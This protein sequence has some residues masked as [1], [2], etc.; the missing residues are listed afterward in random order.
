[1]RTAAGIGGALLGFALACGPSPFSCDD[2]AQCSRAPDGACEAGGAC[3]YPDTACESG[4]RYSGLGPLRPGECTD[5]ERGTG[6]S[7][8]DGTTGGAS[9]GSSVGDTL[10]L[11]EGSSSDDA[12]GEEST[13]GDD[14][15]VC[16]GI[17]CSGEGTCVVVD[18]E[19]TC[20]CDPG[21]TMVGTECL[22]DPCETTTC[23]FVDD[24]DGDDMAEGSREAPWRTADRVETAIGDAMPG[25]HFLFR[26][27]GTFTGGEIL[28]VSGVDGTAEAPIVIGAYGPV[29]EARPRMIPLSFQ[30][31][32]SSYIVVRD[33]MIEGY[34]DGGPCFNFDRTDHITIH[35]NETTDCAIRAF[36][37]WNQASHTT[38]FRNAFRDG[39]NKTSIFISDTSWS[40]P[41][42][43]VGSHHWIA[44]NV[45]ANNLE[46]GIE[47]VIADDAGG[48][49]KIVGNQ[50]ADVARRGIVLA[51]RYGWVVNNTVVNA[52]T[53]T[54][55]ESSG[56]FAG[57]GDFVVRG[58][59]VAT[60]DAGIEVNGGGEVAANTVLQGAAQR[61]QLSEGPSPL[62]A[63][64]NLLLA[65]GGRAL[66]VAGDTPDTWLT[67]DRTIFG[68]DAS[69]ECEIR[70]DSTN[71]DFAG[72]QALGFDARGS[73]SQ[74]DGLS[75]VA[76]GPQPPFDATVWGAA[77]PDPAGGVCDSAG[78]LDCDGQPREATFGT[79]PGLVDG[80][81]LGWP[82]PLLIQQRYPLSP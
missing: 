82:G 33:L 66:T 12:I 71:V 56:L 23:Y 31:F 43:T 69:A 7:G 26:R 10:A 24:V 65:P 14:D 4:R 45:I 80:E 30:I 42:A 44:D 2:D 38:I 29:S 81:G 13:G 67:M 15:T 6:T 70:V 58:N 39:G 19:P 61:L 73:C 74:V 49:V 32:D 63:L 9:G 21:W 53:D 17:D 64:D 35:D 75:A 28:R 41:P 48:D 3:S 22:E 46:N 51:A 27:G 76:P 5:P 79:L 40:T 34:V 72:W 16:S 8:G 11:E 54:E 55:A 57:S 1:M 20:A 62:V 59:V 77:T 47:V 36:R 25:D 18:G 52:G 37:I 78:A 68:S 60:D 50:V